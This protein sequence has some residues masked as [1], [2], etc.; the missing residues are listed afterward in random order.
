M[1]FNQDHFLAPIAPELSKENSDSEGRVDR[2]ELIVNVDNTLCHDTRRI[3]EYFIRKK[4]MT[5]SI[6][7]IAHVCHRVTSGSSVIPK[8]N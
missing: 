6:Q 8:S 7:F 2:N 5:T 4:M 3:Q 1:E